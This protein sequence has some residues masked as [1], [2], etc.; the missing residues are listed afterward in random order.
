MNTRDAN[1]SVEEIPPSCCSPQADRVDCAP[2]DL[3]RSDVVPSKISVG[4]GSGS[5]STTSMALLTGGAFLMGSNDRWAY[6]A[7]WRE[8]GQ[9]SLS[10]SIL[11][12]LHAVS[13]ARFAEFVKDTHYVT[14]VEG[15]GW[16]FVFGGLLPDDFPPTQAVAAAPWCRRV[17]GADWRHPA[18]PRSS[19][20]HHLDH[21]RSFT[22]PGT[23]HK[24]TVAG[25]ASGCQP[26]PSGN[27]PPAAALRVKP[28]PGVTTGSRMG[29]PNE[30]PARTLP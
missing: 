20:A 3:P 11:D 16:S 2:S 17:E 30:C 25:R 21:L 12:R 6:P 18:G 5:G 7:D 8:P 1:V 19:V 4:P 28:S 22:S 15:F 14:E 29:T 10:R 9:P 26:R 13:N 27:T 23:T 24:A